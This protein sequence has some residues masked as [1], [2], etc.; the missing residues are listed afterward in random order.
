MNPLLTWRQQWPG[1]T[2]LEYDT[3]IQKVRKF[4]HPSLDGLS[5]IQLLIYVNTW[6]LW[7]S[8]WNMWYACPSLS[9]T[10]VGFEKCVYAATQLLTNLQAFLR[11]HVCSSVVL[12]TASQ[13]FQ[14]NWK[15]FQEK[16]CTALASVSVKT[17]PSP[18]I[19]QCATK[20]E[21]A[22]RDVNK[23]Q[24]NDG[25]E[26]MFQMVQFII[27]SFCMYFYIDRC[28][29]FFYQWLL[30]SVKEMC[31][32]LFSILLITFFHLLTNQ[33]NTFF[34]SYSSFNL[35]PKCL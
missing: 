8:C 33:N 3:R 30:S 11:V 25:A 20:S 6:K 19:H 22:L 29:W 5:T 1:F 12:L 27:F 32:L 7:L 23:S 18:N 21:R 4:Q 15:Y 31:C 16:S 9:S 35:K 17:P 34:I 13:S 24:A 28:Q 26:I 10:S 2:L 14:T